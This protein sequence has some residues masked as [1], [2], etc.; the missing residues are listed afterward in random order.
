MEALHSTEAPKK[1]ED[2]LGNLAPRTYHFYLLHTTMIFLNG[3]S[4]EHK[5]AGCAVWVLG[6]PCSAQSLLL[7][8]AGSSFLTCSDLMCS[9]AWKTSG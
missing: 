6:R 2:F 1:G 5:G 9:D 4:R 7:L 3:A 8:Q